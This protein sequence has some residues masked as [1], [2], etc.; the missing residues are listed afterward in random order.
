LASGT[1]VWIGSQ[2]AHDIAE[3]QG[4]LPNNCLIA[5]TDDTANGQTPVVMNISNSDANVNEPFYTDKTNSMEVFK[6][7]ADTMFNDIDTSRILKVYMGHATAYTTDDSGYPNIAVSNY[8][9]S[10]CWG[11]N[12]H[13]YI[14]MRIF[15]DWGGEFKFQRS[16]DGNCVIDEAI[17]W[18]IAYSS[19]SGITIPNNDGAGLLM[20]LDGSGSGTKSIIGASQIAIVTDNS[21]GRR[22]SNR[23]VIDNID[24]AGCYSESFIRSTEYHTSLLF[25]VDFTTGQI[26]GTCNFGSWTFTAP[27]ITKVLYR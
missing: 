17:G 25:N 23:V 10:S 16:Q 3:S 13:P 27:K 21:M 20:T 9:A 6:I 8:I 26:Y 1:R 14:R 7:I 5:I 15:T 24:N 12:G 4:K 18:H 22:I 19:S 11:A 2:S